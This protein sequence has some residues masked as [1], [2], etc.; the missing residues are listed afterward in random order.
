MLK[1]FQLLLLFFGLL[2]VSSCCINYTF[3]GANLPKEVKTFSVAYIENK[4]QIVA[5]QL[6][7]VFTEKLKNKLTNETSLKSQRTNGDLRFSGFISSYS[8]NNA[9]QQSNNQVANNRLTIVVE[10]TCVN[11]KDS[12]LNYKQQFSNFA[13]F[14]GTQ[15][16]NAVEAKLINDI[17]DLL[18]LEIFNK[19]VINW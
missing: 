13:D 19:A 8:V 12:T 14:P 6:S 10:I 15:N 5:P 18:I 11:T 7:N 16:L 17:S 9:S 4:A 2:L 1:S 3:K